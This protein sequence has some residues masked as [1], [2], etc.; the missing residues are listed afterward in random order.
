MGDGGDDAHSLDR[1]VDAHSL[2]RMAA[3]TDVAVIVLF[4]AGVGARVIIGAV[5]P[6]D[7]GLLLIVGVD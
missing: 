7:A 4:L 2:Q 6:V 3:S 5:L 1:V